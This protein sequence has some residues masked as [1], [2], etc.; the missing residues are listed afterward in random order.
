MSPHSTTRRAARV[1]HG[2]STVVRAEAGANQ[3]SG[4]APQQGFAM[5]EVLVTL[6]ILLIGL[7]GLAGIIARS[8][9]V[10]L[11]S[12]QRVQALI[13][14]QDMVDRINANRKYAPCYS[15]GGSGVTLGNGYSG[16]PACSASASLTLA[17]ERAQ[18]VA[19]LV[20]WDNLLKG[21]GE[22][23][24]TQ[25]VGAMI[26]ARGCITQVDAANRIYR[27]SVVWQG[28]ISTVASNDTCGQAANA[29]G[30]DGRRRVVTTTVRIAS[31]S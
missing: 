18:A 25:K 14:A 13:L 29:Y 17:A 2:T 7:L 27:V 23:Q 5:L 16:T 11:E 30:G 4:R 6:I 20:A 12:Y 26:G 22:V 31:L 15:N 21:A 19:D 3:E 24:G 9:A 10:E 28:M 8:N 1:G